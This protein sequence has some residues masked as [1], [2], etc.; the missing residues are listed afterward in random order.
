MTCQTGASV[1]T[2]RAC[3][4]DTEADPAVR[5]STGPSWHDGARPG[6]RRQDQLHPRADEGADRVRRRAQRDEDEPE[7]DHCAADVWS[8]RRRH[9]RLDGRHLLDALETNPQNQ[10]GLL[11]LPTT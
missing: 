7:S 11:L 4:V 1:R 5:D 2:D 6:R 9:Q 3:A 8:A 10:E